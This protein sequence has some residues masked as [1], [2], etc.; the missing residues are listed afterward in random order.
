MSVATCCGRLP[1]PSTSNAATAADSSGDAA[2]D[3]DDDDDG[4]AMSRRR[5]LRR[6]YPSSRRIV[7]RVG[8]CFSCLQP[9]SAGIDGD[10]D[11]PWADHPGH[12]N[13]LWHRVQDGLSGAVR[14]A[15]N[16]LRSLIGSPRSD[17]PYRPADGDFELLDDGQIE[18]VPPA[19]TAIHEMIERPSPDD[20]V[21]PS[22]SSDS[23]DTHSFYGDDDDD[24]EGGDD[25]DDDITPGAEESMIASDSSSDG[26]GDDY[27]S[28]MSSSSL[29]TSESDDDDDDDDGGDS[30]P[31]SPSPRPPK[32]RHRRP[33]SA[34]ETNT[35]P[36][37]RPSPA[38][39]AD[40]PRYSDKVIYQP[41]SYAFGQDQ[42][43]HTQ[44]LD[45]IERN[46]NVDRWP[47]LERS[48]DEC[49]RSLSQQM[50][51]LDQQIETIAQDLRIII[52]RIVSSSSSSS[53]PSIDTSR[54]AATVAVQIQPSRQIFEKI[55]V[56][57][58]K[59]RAWLDIRTW[60]A[61]ALRSLKVIVD[62]GSHTRSDE[63]RRR[64]ALKMLRTIQMGIVKIRSVSRVICSQIDFRDD[65][66]KR[67][68]QSA[69]RRF[70]AD[71]ARRLIVH[72]FKRSPSP[73][74]LKLEYP[75]EYVSSSSLPASSNLTI[76]LR[77]HGR[78]MELLDPNLV[79][80]GNVDHPQDDTGR[81]DSV[82]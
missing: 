3:D 63:P 12:R 6:N 52:L 37:S 11:D 60:M 77:W 18:T 61:T 25:D 29:L 72:R 24:D 66:L 54:V 19:T 49:R 59:H 30:S 81:D 9:S 36:P 27:L 55:L 7:C 58:A 71:N 34:P 41:P 20:T 51:L 48:I 42:T 2:G 45:W 23:D 28:P 79:R 16:S 38:A 80:Y 50:D 64:T 78:W 33:S 14:S 26:D 8:R 57:A 76:V 82:S 67:H 46:V 17:R 75:S 35:Q 13:G 4:Q 43:R 21:A 70:V 31:P 32:S 39:A 47:A 68:V 40:P 73:V 1:T 74:P 65:L 53:S 5:R 44:D 62:I 22:S 10:D 15:Q 69:L 56:P